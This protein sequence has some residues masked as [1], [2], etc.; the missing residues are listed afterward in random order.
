MAE[1]KKSKLALARLIPDS[2]LVKDSDGTNL[3]VPLNADGNRI[4][5]M[6][7]AAKMRAMLERTLKA[8]KDEDARLTP[9]ELADLASAASKIEQFAGEVYKGSDVSVPTG[10][11]PQK[12]VEAE[13]IDFEVLAPKKNEAKA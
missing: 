8:V 5:G 6:I 2:A 11:N 9:K 7:M 12:Q 4:M 1:D 10:D 13:K 3:T